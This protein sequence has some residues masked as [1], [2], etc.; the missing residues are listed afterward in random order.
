MIVGDR[1][2]HVR[3]GTV[4]HVEKIEYFG[5]ICF[6]DVRALTPNNEPSCVVSTCY[7]TNL[8]VVSEKVVPMPRS[9]AW[10]EE[11]RRFCAAIEQALEEVDDD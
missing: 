6:M 2:R 10:W 1:A 7:A 5:G 11:S 9:A 8:E 3:E 4:G